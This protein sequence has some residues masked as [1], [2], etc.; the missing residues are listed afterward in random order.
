MIKSVWLPVLAAVMLVV[1]GCGDNDETSDANQQE[2]P[3]SSSND[4]A[5]GS[6]G[7]EEEEPV[8]AELDANG[9]EEDSDTIESRQAEEE[10]ARAEALESD[11]VAEEAAPQTEDVEAGEDTLAANPED[12]LEEGGAM[13][14]EA[15]RSDVDEM[16][17]ETERRFEEAQQ[18]LDEQFQEVEEQAPV[19][20]PIS[21]EE[22]E[23]RWE[24]DSSLPE[25]ARDE[26]RT[27]G[28]NIDEL[29]EDTER[30]FEEAEQ[31]LNEQFESIEAERPESFELEE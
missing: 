14:G 11:T 18:R 23:E 29:I 21:D 19:I 26:E 30:R 4:V 22:M 1:S 5:A 28:S 15:T 3:A 31:R 10:L 8:T 7:A 24:F 13:P 9:S 12:V 20:E 16:I 6:A 25:S 17:A 2:E 27:R